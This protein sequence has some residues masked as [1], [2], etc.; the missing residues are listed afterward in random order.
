MPLITLHTA[1]NAPA[2]IVFN[3]SRSIDLHK[4]SA[5]HTNEEA[6]PPLDRSDV[7]ARTS[8][9]MELNETV[10]WK[11][12]HFGITQ[13][14]TVRITAFEQNKSFTDEMV[15]EGGIFKVMEHKH[16]FKE[17][18]GVTLMTD[19]FYYESPLG[20]LGRLADA[21]FLK[22]YMHNFL[23]KRNLVIKEIAEDE[24]K[25]NTLLP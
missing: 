1:I 13:H 11:A 4:I 20:I 5:A 18:D 14:L 7:W 21:L 25:R 16:L 19:L 10:T 24:N 15:P 6:V 12:R 3:L 2:E 22:R 9:L 17:K 23:L 8:G